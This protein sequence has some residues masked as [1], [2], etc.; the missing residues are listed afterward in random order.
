MPTSAARSDA[1][2]FGAQ[3]ETRPP[4]ASSSASPP[5]REAI[6]GRP[7][8]SASSVAIGKP[9]GA[10]RR[11]HARRLHV[12][13]GGG[14]PRRNLVAR[15][16]ARQAQRD[17]AAARA[18]AQRR[19]LGTGAQDH[20]IDVAAGAASATASI[21]RSNPLIGTRRPT[22]STV[23]R[24]KPRRPRAAA[25]SAAETGWKSRASGA[26]GSTRPTRRPASAAKRRRRSSLTNVEIG[27]RAG[28]PARERAPERQALEQRDVARVRDGAVAQPGRGGDRRQRAGDQPVAHDRV[29]SRGGGAHLAA[30]RGGEMRG[31]RSR[32]ARRAARA[33]PAR[34]RRRRARPRAAPRR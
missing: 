9:F 23:G 8:A 18:R 32:R 29:P 2:S 4:P 20:E 13:I 21:S 34:R 28:E 15:D 3:N 11:Q 16:E 22:E 24:A 12:E 25:R 10:A 26:S 19:L 30:E 33:S 5:D 14:E 1:T 7:T 6:T 27:A 31:L 17:A